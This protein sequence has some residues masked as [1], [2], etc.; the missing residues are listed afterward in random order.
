MIRFL[1]GILFLFFTYHVADPILAQE[2]I[3]S[4]K[5]QRNTET[6]FGDTR[7]RTTKYSGKSDVSDGG[8]QSPLIF[9]KT[10]GGAGVA[11]AADYFNVSKEKILGM[12]PTIALFVVFSVF[13]VLVVAIV[14]LSQGGRPYD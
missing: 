12:D 3:Q 9:Q 7:N 11:Q 8:S 5:V 2:F 14:A 1:M 4:R 13:L 10:A 6:Q